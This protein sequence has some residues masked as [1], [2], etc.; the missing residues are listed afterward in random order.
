MPVCY[1]VSLH[2]CQWWTH[3]ARASGAANVTHIP[4]NST[5]AYRGARPLQTQYWC[6][7]MRAKHRQKWVRACVCECFSGL[8]APLTLSLPLTHASILLYFVTFT[9][10]TAH[11]SRNDGW[12]TCD[13]RD[14]IWSSLFWAPTCCCLLAL[15]NQRVFF[16][17]L[18]ME[19]L[20]SHAKQ[21]MASYR[22]M[23]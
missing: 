1:C 5:A 10:F 22:S 21:I 9:V 19:L 14:L 2:H 6:Y 8:R 4:W 20:I 7:I 15:R 13:L 12:I 18:P 17:F 3:W 11:N 16:F 23:C